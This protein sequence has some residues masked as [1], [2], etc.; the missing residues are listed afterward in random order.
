MHSRPENNR[1][2]SIIPCWVFIFILIPL[3]LPILGF[4]LWEKIEV[5]VWLEIGYHAFN[6]FIMLLLMFSYL[7]E[8]WFMVTTDLLFYL[9]HVALTASL[10][11]GAELILCF[12]LFLLRVDVSYLLNCL[13]IAEMSASHSPLLLLD[14]QPILGTITLSVFSPITICTLFYCLGFAPVCCWKPWLAYLCISV[15]TLIPPLMDIFWRGDAQFLLSA[16]IIHL[17]IHLLACWSYQKTDNVWTPIATLAVTNLI[18][19]IA[20]PIL[21]F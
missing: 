4:G 13:P 14:V 3:F 12:L 6:C 7:K 8:D 9:K 15:V 1:V 18:L 20:L 21:L 10:I 2:V 19:S 16:Y 5:S 17:P 11:I